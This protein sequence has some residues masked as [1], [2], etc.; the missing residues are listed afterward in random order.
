MVLLF[1]YGSALVANAI[2]LAVLTTA[3]FVITAAK[4]P[5]AIM[6]WLVEHDLIAD[7]VAAIGTYLLLGQT[8]TS[9][10]AAAIVGIMTDILLWTAKPFILKEDR[11]A[12][13]EI[14]GT[15]VER[16]Q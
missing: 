2:L 9:L 1:A 10:L 16:I 7:V 14:E 13:L 11:E 6:R 4:L 12:V 8:V 15:V 5:R 3:G